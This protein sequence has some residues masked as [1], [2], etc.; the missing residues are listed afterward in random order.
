MA[1]KR[2]VCFLD[3]TVNIR[4]VGFK[5]YFDFNQLLYVYEEIF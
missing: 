3:K 1:E 5:Q 4:Y 2:I